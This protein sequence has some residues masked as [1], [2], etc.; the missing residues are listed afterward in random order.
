MLKKSTGSGGGKKI[1]L[2][3]ENVQFFG[4]SVVKSRGVP[5]REDQGHI[6]PFGQVGE[7]GGG[8]LGGEPGDG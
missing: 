1:G 4:A 6:P 2:N 7:R 3:L 8:G 5:L